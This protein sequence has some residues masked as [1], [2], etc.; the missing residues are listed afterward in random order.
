MPKPAKLKTGTHVVFCYTSDLEKA[1][2]Y[3]A[4]LLG[5]TWVRVLLGKGDVKGVSGVLPALA[6]TAWL[7]GHG[8]KGDRRIGTLARG[9]YVEIS[10]LLDW[11]V[12]EGYS[13]VVDTCCQPDSRRLTAAEYPLDYYAGPDSVDVY[14][15]QQ[16][17]DFD[18][19][20]DANKMALRS[21]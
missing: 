21:S 4:K 1:S 9:N 10:V 14:Q 8:L 16:F 12:G 6:D 13:A 7:V 3:L 18:S 20:W 15:I 17:K 2:A 11:L 5:C 19:W